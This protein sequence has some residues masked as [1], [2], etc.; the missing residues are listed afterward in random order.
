MNLTMNITDMYGKY[1]HFHYNLPKFA[2][3]IN[4]FM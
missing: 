3:S 4:A 2:G 1:H